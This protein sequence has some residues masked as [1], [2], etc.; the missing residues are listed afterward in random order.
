MRRRDKPASCCSTKASSATAAS[1]TAPGRSGR[2]KAKRASQEWCSPSFRISATMTR[3]ST[4]L[5]RACS[6]SRCPTAGGIAGVRAAPR[7]HRCTPPSA[8]S[9][10]CGIMKTVGATFAP[11][12]WRS[13]GEGNFCS[14]TG[15]SAR[16]APGTSLNPNSFVFRF[17]RAGITTSCVGS[18]TSRRLTRRATRA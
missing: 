5:P 16:I 18:I 13:R 2:S 8:R 1:A 15:C 7:T 14:P 11:C 12:A 4:R 6:K 17:R 3:A 10:A 9:K